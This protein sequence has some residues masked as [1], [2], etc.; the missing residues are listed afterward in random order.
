MCLYRRYAL[1]DNLQVSLSLSL[2]CLAIPHLCILRFMYT[3]FFCIL[4]YCDHIRLR[5]KN[6]EKCAHTVCCM[7]NLIGNE[8]LSTGIPSEVSYE[9]LTAINW[10]LLSSLYPRIPATIFSIRSSSLTHSLNSFRRWHAEKLISN[11]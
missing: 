7:I 6:Y 8:M 1:I 11:S 5:V 10:I 9:K 2:H 3:P 4:F